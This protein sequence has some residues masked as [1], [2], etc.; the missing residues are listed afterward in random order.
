MP[1]AWPTAGD[2]MTSRPVTLPHDAL[3]S[4]ALGVMRSHRYHQVPVLR[5]TR[6]IGMITIESIARRGRWSLSTK[7]EHLLVVPPLVLLGTP[8]PEVAEQLLATGMR[9]APVVGRRGELLGIISRTDLVR[10]M[11]TLS[12]LRSGDGPNVEEIARST[13]ETI[14]ENEQ[15]RNLVTQLR[16][17]E[18]HPLPVVDRKGKIVGAIGIGDLGE[19]LGR[20]IHGGKRDARANRTSL[21]VEVRSVMRAP[22]VAV[23]L[24]T[25]ALEAARVMTREKVSSVFV[26]EDGRPTRVVGQADLLGLAIS[27]A[28]PG[29]TRDGIENVYVEITGLRGSADP[30]LI[31]EIDGGVAKGLHRIARY[32]RPTLLTLHFAPQGTHRTNDLTVEAR[33]FT[34]QGRIFYASH[35]GWN[36][37]AGVAGLLDELL[38]Q[39]RR[40]SETP[41]GRGRR[42]VQTP[43]AD[44][45]AFE[46]PDLEAKIRAASGDDDEP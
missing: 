39:V 43:A 35:T 20:P 5:N 28:R 4:T 27:R 29:A 6:L 32:A 3:I 44:D 7:V 19:V 22:A 21:E 15:V 34:E 2:L 30:G 8:F 12:I 17:L 14:R 16:L 23:P 25:P 1:T 36:L 40:L 37:M 18:E 31:S 24:G 33:L 42:R 46:D 9:A 45:A 41:R 26:V 11:P 13:G 10:A 38:A